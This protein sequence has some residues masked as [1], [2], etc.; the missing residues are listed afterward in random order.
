MWEFK[1]ARSVG[2]ALVGYGLIGYW[3]IADRGPRVEISQA[4]IFGVLVAVIA[5]IMVVQRLRSADWG[6]PSPR[7]RAL[8]CLLG[9]GIAACWLYAA[10]TTVA[11]GARQVEGTV[12]NCTSTHFNRKTHSSSCGLK[13][14]DGSTVLSADG[15]HPGDEGLRV[16]YLPDQQRLVMPM[17]DRV[18][19]LVLAGAFGGYALS[20]VVALLV[21]SVRGAAKSTRYDSVPAVRMQGPHRY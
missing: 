17:T 6:G 8:G 18:T 10:G 1:I 11:D 15:T 13:L 12:T 4:L 21:T 14:D 19:Y 5:S 2:M 7:T 16:S 20:G 9:F 3:F